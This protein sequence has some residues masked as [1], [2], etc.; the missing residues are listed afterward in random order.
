MASE[1]F[2]HA[3]LLF[4][5]LFLKISRWVPLSV[6]RGAKHETRKWPRAWLKAPLSRARALLSLNLKEKRDC[7]HVDNVSEPTILSS[8]SFFEPEDEI[9]SRSGVPFSMPDMCFTYATFSGFIRTAMRTSIE[10]DRGGINY[11]GKWEAGGGVKKRKRDAWYI[12]T[13][14]PSFLRPLVAVNFRLVQVLVFS[15]PLIVITPSCSLFA[16]G[17]RSLH[18]VINFSLLICNVLATLCTLNFSNNPLRKSQCIRLSHF[19]MNVF[20]L[21]K[22]EYFLPIGVTSI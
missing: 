20:K 11:Q 16:P 8:S 12:R 7:S 19:L 21:G 9:S 17:S 6:V 1:S 10:R 15:F 5:G 13:T 14:L 2:I 3:L 18:F 22:P 4:L